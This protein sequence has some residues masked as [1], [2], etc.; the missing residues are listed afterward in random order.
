MITTRLNAGLMDRL[1]EVRGLCPEM[2]VGQFLATIGLL[3]ADESGH[4]L[5]EAEDGELAVA[6]ERFA[7][8]LSRRGEST[9]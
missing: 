3:V 6:L 1:N 4:S 2:R 5:W 7:A 9:T 8:D